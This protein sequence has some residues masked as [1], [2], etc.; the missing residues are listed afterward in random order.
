MGCLLWFCYLCLRRVVDWFG[1][2]NSVDSDYSLCLLVVCLVCG[3][4][5]YLVVLCCLL[6]AGCLMASSCFVLMFGVLSFITY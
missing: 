3:R 5:V 1:S 2:V 6:I 4:F